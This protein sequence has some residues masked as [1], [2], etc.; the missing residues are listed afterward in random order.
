MS[1][2]QGSTALLRF[3]VADTFTDAAACER[4]AATTHRTLLD[5]PGEERTVVAFADLQNPLDPFTRRVRAGLLAF[6]FRVE[7]VKLPA[8]LLRLLMHREVQSVARAT[9][10]EKLSK[11]ERTQIKDTLQAR[12]AARANPQIDVVEC[13]WDTHAGLLYVDT[14]SRTTL[15]LLVEHFARATSTALRSSG[16]LTALWRQGWTQDMLDSYTAGPTVATVTADNAHVGQEFA[17]WLWM[18]AQRDAQ[19]VLAPG[20]RCTMSAGFRRVSLADV[21][22]LSD[23]EG[24]DLVQQGYMPATMQIHIRPSD[25]GVTYTATLDFRT[26]TLSALKVP[27]LPGDT[28][29]HIALLLD[30]E[31]AVLSAYEIFADY[32]LL[33]R[34]RQQRV[35]RA[36]IEECGHAVE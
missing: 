1:L 24:R 36:W 13:L 17:L 34:E 20:A 35:L 4:L 33:S 32:R 3:V 18:H 12:L 16:L 7:R 6:A 30:A 31:S 11:L 10:R 8:K 22:L 9:G 28:D 29:A 19:A 26:L 21:D 2:T 5:T 25:S 15:G 23:R 27:S 14:A